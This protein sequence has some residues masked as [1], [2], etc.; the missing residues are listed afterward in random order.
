M[1][2]QQKKIWIASKKTDKNNIEGS[3]IYVL[4]RLSDQLYDMSFK[5]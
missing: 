5:V 2:S 4:T 3:V 1:I